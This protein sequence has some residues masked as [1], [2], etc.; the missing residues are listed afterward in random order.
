MNIRKTLAAVA[1]AEE[2]PEMKCPKGWAN[3][4][5]HF[6]QHKENAFFNCDFTS[7]KCL[8]GFA[9]LRMKLYEVLAPDRETVIG[10]YFCP[11]QF[12]CLDFNAGT[13]VGFQPP[14]KWAPMGPL[15][16]KF[17]EGGWNG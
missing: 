7:G 10:R 15:E 2:Q 13:L 12:T 17:C 3:S 16:A 8:R 1:V 4:W 6:S 14:G 5:E 11:T 9:V